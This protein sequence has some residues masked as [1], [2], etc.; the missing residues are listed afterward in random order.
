MTEQTLSIFDLRDIVVPEPVGF[1]PPAAG[2]WVLVGVAGC[3]L[4]LLIWRWYV[5]W[6]SGAYRRAALAYLTQIEGQLAAP[7]KESVALHELSVLLKRVALAAFP[8]KEVAP[9][10]G[11]NWLR[12]L[13]RTCG[14][15]T[16]MTGPGRLLTEA[17]FAVPSA[18][19]VNADDCKQLVKLANTWIKGHR[20]L[21]NT[22]VRN[23]NSE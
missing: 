22:D 8:R 10:Y 1:W 2:V 20:I 17:R 13:D 11:E 5:V 21:K 18:S 12:F 23:Q 7:G 16:F 14:G 6:K 9:F 19:H 4:T 15:C 3:A